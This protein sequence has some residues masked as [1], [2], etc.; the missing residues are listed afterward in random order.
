MGAAFGYYL[1]PF[2]FVSVLTFQFAPLPRIVKKDD[3]TFNLVEVCRGL[4]LFPWPPPPPPYVHLYILFH[5]DLDINRINREKSSWA[6]SLSDS[7]RMWMPLSRPHQGLPWP[8]R[9]AHQVP[10]LYDGSW[11]RR[12]HTNHWWAFQSIQRLF[13]N[14][15]FWFAW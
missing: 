11:R 3:G 14:F 13:F 5:G 15:I 9:N 8:D 1:P 12:S 10:C 6:L 7:Y 4:S 2:C